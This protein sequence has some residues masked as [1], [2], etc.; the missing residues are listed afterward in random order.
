MIKNLTPEH[1]RCFIGNCPSLQRLGDGRLL[2]VGKEASSDDLAGTSA[3]IGDDEQAIVISQ[4]LLSDLI[5]EA[6]EAWTPMEKAVGG[7]GESLLVVDAHGNQYVADF[8]YASDG[9]QYWQPTGL[10]AR[11][12]YVAF[13]RLPTPPVKETME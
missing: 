5:S 13:R 7:D 8:A 10:P 3:D 1:M 12:D 4:D 6:V 2:I 11:C 9:K